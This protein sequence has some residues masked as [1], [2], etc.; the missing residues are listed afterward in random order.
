MSAKSTVLE[1]GENSD[2]AVF[3]ELLPDENG[4]P[5]LVAIS[6]TAGTE[7]GSATTGG[8]GWVDQESSTVA[9]IVDDFV[10]N[11]EGDCS[12]TCK[13]ETQ[14]NL[15]EGNENLTADNAANAVF[16]ESDAN[17]VD[18]AQT[19]LIAAGAP[20]EITD[21]VEILGD[22]IE[23]ISVSEEV[24]QE[25]IN[26]VWQ[27]APSEG[28]IQ[29]MPPTDFFQNFGDAALINESEGFQDLGFDHNDQG[30]FRAQHSICLLYTSP[31]P[32]D[33]LLSRM[34]SSA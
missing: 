28:E 3:S 29:E 12:Y 14:E 33:G 21:S 11:M 5:I 31:R 20:Q 30:D 6:Q 23:D 19:L 34:P 25:F 13:A 24:V 9:L 15:S 18:L 7:L 26:E 10:S 17:R 32:R 22:A 4:K 16:T 1:G 8:S 27:Q 2:D